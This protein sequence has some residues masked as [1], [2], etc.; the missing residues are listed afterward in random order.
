MTTHRIDLQATEKGHGKT[1]M[2]YLGEPI[3]T[4]DSPRAVSCVTGGV[5]FRQVAGSGTTNSRTR[6]CGS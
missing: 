2:F 4:S 3:G 5:K 6:T 1:R